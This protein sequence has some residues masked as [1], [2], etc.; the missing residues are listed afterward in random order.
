MEQT[1]PT[2]A[3]TARLPDAFY[4]RVRR[5]A[6][7]E[8]VSINQIVVTA[9]GQYLR[10]TER[11]RAIRAAADLQRELREKYGVQPDSTPLIRAMR[12]ERH[13]DLR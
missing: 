7:Q 1:E 12:E 9:V 4:Q 8:R 5:L 11:D 6:E 10:Q 2:Q 13:A 3:I